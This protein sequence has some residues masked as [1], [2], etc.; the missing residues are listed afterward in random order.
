[1]ASSTALVGQLATTTGQYITELVPFV[2][3]FVGTAIAFF[4]VGLIIK[5]IKRVM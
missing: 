4:A 3:L 2:Y 5:S 1:M